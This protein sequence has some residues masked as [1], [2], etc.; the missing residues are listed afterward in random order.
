MSAK[1][2]P[3]EIRQRAVRMVFEICEQSGER[4][5]VIGRVARQLGIGTESLRGWVRQVRDRR[6]PTS[7][8]DHRGAAAHRRVG[9]RES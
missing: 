2:Y 3:E 1:R 5:G 9:T 4:K 6:R 7:R 8:R